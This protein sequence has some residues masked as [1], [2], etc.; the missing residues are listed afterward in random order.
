MCK[1]VITININ[2]VFLNW[3][4]S[5][6]AGILKE[7]REMSEN[8]STQLLHTIMYNKK[9]STHVF[10]NIHFNTFWNL[11]KFLTIHF[12]DHWFLCGRNN[13]SESDTAV[14]VYKLC[15]LK[16][17]PLCRTAMTSMESKSKVLQASGCSETVRIF[18]LYDRIS[19]R[20]WDRKC[21]R[22]FIWSQMG[23]NHEVD[24]LVTHSL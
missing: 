7:F 8:I 22:K 11:I 24:N 16:N 18:K 21:L 23:S 20:H 15:N 2:K 9:W 4:E 13:T 10:N 14:K 19:R 3:I 17:C 5:K 1:P 12:W 6:Y